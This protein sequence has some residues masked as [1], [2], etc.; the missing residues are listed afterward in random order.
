MSLLPHY[1]ALGEDLTI[2][3][4]HGCWMIGH[5]SCRIFIS[6]WSASLEFQLLGMEL[7]E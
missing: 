2:D 5:A 6:R 3:M 7:A 4:V 1:T